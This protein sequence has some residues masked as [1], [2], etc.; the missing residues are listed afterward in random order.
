MVTN[1]VKFNFFWTKD[2]PSNMRQAYLAPRSQRYGN[3]NKHSLHSQ[4]GGQ[5][6]YQPRAGPS[7]SWQGRSG[8][9]SG[10][11]LWQPRELPSKPEGPAS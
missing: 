1:R 5:F 11:A 6:E 7:P 3:E 2:V 10:P 8:P 4:G 9:S